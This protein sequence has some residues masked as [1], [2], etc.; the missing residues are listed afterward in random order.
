MS[1]HNNHPT[2]STTEI[3][4]RVEGLEGASLSDLRAIES[5]LKRRE[6][7]EEYNK[8]EE[9]RLRRKAYNQRKAEEARIGRQLLV[10][11]LA[12]K[13]VTTEETE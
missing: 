5:Y 9:V 6:Y 8:R 4:E 3:R 2:L 11:L 13:P 12:T 10:Q 1:K 7:R